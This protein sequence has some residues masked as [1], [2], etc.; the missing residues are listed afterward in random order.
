MNTGST[1]HPI[2]G[3]CDI[4]FDQDHATLIIYVTNANGHIVEG[5]SVSAQLLGP[6]MPGTVVSGTTTQGAANGLHLASFRD[7]PVVVGYVY[8]SSGMVTA[9]NSGQFS[10]H[11]TVTY[12][13]AT[14]SF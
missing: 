12:S 8:Y 7:I 11:G 10:C 6:G 13:G 5:A 3:A 9:Q 1:A 14:A 2:Q 4:I